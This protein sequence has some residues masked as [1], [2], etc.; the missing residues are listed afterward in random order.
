MVLESR[1][2][3][4]THVSQAI[5][6]DQI[7]FVIPEVPEEVLELEGDLF[8]N[9]LLRYEVSDGSSGVVQVYAHRW[10]HKSCNQKVL[11]KQQ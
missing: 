7:L 10:L 6:V 4:C 5:L 2:L 11:Q 8:L 3:T 1:G 9:W